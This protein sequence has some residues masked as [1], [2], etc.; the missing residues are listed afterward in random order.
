MTTFEVHGLPV[1]ILVLY[2]FFVF[3]F[4]VFSFNFETPF[5][6]DLQEP[7]AAQG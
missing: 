7:T 4:L 1:S 2:M 5:H 3:S 6:G